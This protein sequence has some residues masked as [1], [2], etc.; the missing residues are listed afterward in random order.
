MR[1]I[2]NNSLRFIVVKYEQFTN[3]Y[4][5]FKN[6]LRVQCKLLQFVQALWIID[7]WF[8][9]TYRVFLRILSCG[10]FSSVVWTV[11]NFQWDLIL[12]FESNPYSLVFL[13]F[14]NL[15]VLRENNQYYTTKSFG[16]FAHWHDSLTLIILGKVF[17]Y[18]SQ[19]ARLNSCLFFNPSKNCRKLLGIILKWIVKQSC[20]IANQPVLANA[21]RAL[22]IGFRWL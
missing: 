1:C 12:S 14:R 13:Q 10:L 21:I 9:I 11:M 7:E 8:T 6:K 2:Y 4:D 20:K 3:A 5:I 17:V 22:A 16:F 19:S 15:H 18:Y